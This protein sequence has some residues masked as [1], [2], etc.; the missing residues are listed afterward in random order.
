VSCRRKFNNGIWE[1]RLNPVPLSKV[2]HVLK[3]NHFAFRRRLFYAS[4]MPS[5]DIVSQVNSMEIEN[6]VNQAKKE[7]ANRFDFKGSKAEIVLEK[8][9]IKLTAEDQFKVTT[10]NEM[11][12]GKLSKRGI[13]LKSVEQCE[14]DISPLGHARQL[15]KIKQGIETTVAKQITG[16]IRDGKFKVTT[17]IQG[18]AVR[19]TGKSRD[20]LQ[21]VIGAMRAKEF[22][23]AVQFVNFRD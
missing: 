16:S 22:P 19:V 14:P 2:F 9:E 20:E 23:V 3:L 12:I 1:Q 4:A 5:F 13:S 17:Q 7:L 18:D 21:T 15:I 6:A 10:L 8:N 11:V